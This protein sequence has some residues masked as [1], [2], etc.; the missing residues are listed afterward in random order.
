MAS[1]SEPTER[2]WE[3]VGASETD[4]ASSSHIEPTQTETQYSSDAIQSDAIAMRCNSD[5]ALHQSIARHSIHTTHNTHTSDCCSPTDSFRVNPLLLLTD[6]Q[7][8]KLNLS[9]HLSIG[10][11]R[12]QKRWFFLYH[13]F[14]IKY[15]QILCQFN[16]MPIPR[17]SQTL[18]KC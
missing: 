3:R 13:K 18:T 2:D 17:C 11:K 4:S 9:K 7:K 1:P 16:S 6:R 8:T 14:C 10:L 15:T 5:A 12:S